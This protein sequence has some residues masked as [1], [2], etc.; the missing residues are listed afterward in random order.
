MTINIG[1]FLNKRVKLFLASALMFPSSILLVNLY[2][3]YF[4]THH[5]DLNEL[6]EKD[7]NFVVEVIDHKN[8]PFELILNY[9]VEDYYLNTLSSALYIPP[10]TMKLFPKSN[11]Y[12]HELIRYYDL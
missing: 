1:K 4:N 9:D 10:L 5:I 2:K 8:D 7:L 12:G 11:L 6:L 3:S